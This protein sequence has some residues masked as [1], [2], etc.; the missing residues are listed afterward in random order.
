M[1]K[2][3]EFFIAQRLHKNGGFSLEFS[4]G[5][6]SQWQLFPPRV[7][8]SAE[9]PLGRCLSHRRPPVSCLT[10]VPSISIWRLMMIKSLLHQNL[11]SVPT[12]AT[13]SCNSTHGDPFHLPLH[14]SSSIYIS[15]F[16][17]EY[18]TNLRICLCRTWRISHFNKPTNHHTKTSWYSKEMVLAVWSTTII[19]PKH[20]LIQCFQKTLGTSTRY[21]L[22]LLRIIS[23]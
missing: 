13:P 11:S 3:I 18:A 9:R 7:S 4:P 1:G 2:S 12:V 8:Q 15:L 20:K 10:F 14:S 23:L 17:F 21:I 5:F 19:H 22:P 16:H 6:S